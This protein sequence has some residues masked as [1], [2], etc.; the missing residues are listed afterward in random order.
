DDTSSA[1]VVK[2]ALKEM[3]GFDNFVLLQPTSPARHSEDI[4]CAINLAAKSEHN[5]CV[6]V[7]QSPHNTSWPCTL[8]QELKL[9]KV[10]S[11]R[12]SQKLRG[13]SKIVYINGAIYCSSVGYFLETMEFIGLNT[14]G[15]EMP[16]SRSIDIDTIDDFRKFENY[17]RNK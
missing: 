13:C 3:P 7:T 10:P 12:A 9:K 8:D 5:S 6:S 15:Y 2:H 4:D 17:V 1:D 11:D 14:L 16:V